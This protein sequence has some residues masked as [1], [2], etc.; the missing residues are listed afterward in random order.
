MEE[1]LKQSIP[2]II[3][4]AV[5]LVAGVFVLTKFKWINC[6]DIPGWCSIYCKAA[7]NSRIAMI[8]GASGMGDPKKF[9]KMIMDNTYHV[10]ENIPPSQLSYGVL[11]GYEL[12]IVEKADNLTKKQVQ[13]IQAYLDSGGSVIWVGDSGA[14][15]IEGLKEEIAVS[16]AKE[17]K[18]NETN[19]TNASATP[20]PTPMNIWKETG[21]KN[22]L[23]VD[24][25]DTINTTKKNITIITIMRD[26]PIMMGLKQNIDIKT[27]KVSIVEDTP[28]GST[29]V[30][31]IE[32]D[33]QE[34]PG[35]VENKYVGR[36][37]YFAFPP[38]DLE[39]PTFIMNL[40][41]FLISC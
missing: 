20:T 39:S 25:N 14:R 16:K 18:L 23:L 32:I 38:E 4:I 9:G 11:G 22:Y 15:G 35:I 33:G 21:L 5:L 10:A 29:K 6:H 27:K 36:I 12:V 26:H 24:Y 37:V 17:G 30:A 28:E 34:Y 2:H 31:N 3:L 8:S 7:G 1:E 13:A 41:E 40:I 19:K